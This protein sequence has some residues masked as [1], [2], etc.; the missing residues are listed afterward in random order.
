MKHKLIDFPRR[1]QTLSRKKK[2]IIIFAAAFCLLLAAAGYTLFIAPLKDKDV[3]V[4]KETEV[5]RG[6]LTLGVTESGALEYGIKNIL[7][8][9]DLETGEQD[10]DDEEEETTQRYLKVEEVYVAPGQRIS[11]G[12]P[13]IKF[14]DTSVGSVRRLLEGALVDAKSEYSEAEAEYELAVLEA[15]TDYDT[16][17][18]SQSFADSLYR[19]SKSTIDNDI[20]EIQVE[21]SQRTANITALE[22]KAAAAQEDYEEALEEYQAVKATMDITEKDNT[23][24]F[25]TVQSEYLSAQ[26]NCQNTKTALEQAQEKLSENAEQIT[27]LQDKLQAAQ[28][29]RTIDK[30][31]A[32]QT[33]RESVL[34]GQ[35]AEITYNAKLESLKEELAEAQKDVELAQERLDALEA[36]VEGDGILYAD[37]E[38]VVT[39][40]GYEAG[41]VLSAKG[42]V[43]SYASP[44]D[45]SISVDVTQ[46]DVVSMFVGDK[47]EISFAA[48]PDTIYEGTIHSINTTADS[49]TSATI[50]YTVVISVEGDTSLLYGGMTADIT[51]VTEEKEDALYV[52]RKAI[53]EQGGKTFVYI[54]GALGAKELK[55]VETGLSNSIYTEIVSGL[56]EG[57]TVYIASRVSSEAEVDDTAQD[58]GNSGNNGSLNGDVAGSFSEDGGS[59][60]DMVPGSAGG[61]EAGGGP[62]GGSNDAMRGNGA[63]MGQMPG[64]G[65]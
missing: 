50:S 27:R 7:Y 61:T 31:D 1:F 33:Y 51:F 17:K 10:E 29:K 45:M 23:V 19:S 52:S 6:R 13:L 55:E 14:T 15:K 58:T 25:M 28:G 20:S 4:Y 35:N 5:E 32:E 24:N 34:N 56:E 48:Y 8:D 57:D 12:D 11:P 42:T 46:E 39:S 59:G 62:V 43:V 54:S 65:A 63:P 16:R 26:S 40:V 2:R 22:E 37:G 64:G 38:G 18:V 53:V 9:L 21:I 47:V 41:D 3:W 49:R 30:L 60:I 44:E 36:F